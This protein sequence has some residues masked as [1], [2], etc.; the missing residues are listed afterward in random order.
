MD[1]N[2]VARFMGNYVDRLT[3][4]WFTATQLRQCMANL[5]LFAEFWLSLHL[6]C[7]KTGN[8]R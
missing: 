7:H 3:S 8:C 2:K 5:L 4:V 6:V 1:K